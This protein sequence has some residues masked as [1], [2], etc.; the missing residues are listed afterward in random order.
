MCQGT[1]RKDPLCAMPADLFLIRHAT[2]DWT[3]T[4]LRYDIP[5]GPPLTDNGRAEAQL[6]GRFLAQHGVLRIFVSPM[7]RAHDTAAISSGVA[8]AQV[9]VSEDLT[10]WQRGEEEHRVLERMLRQFA[11]A[12]AL[13]EDRRPV[14]LVTHGGPIR[15]LLSHYGVD[16]ATI[17]YYRRQFDRDNPVP[18]AGVWRLSRTEIDGAWTASLVFSPV[19]YQEFVPV[20]VIV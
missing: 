11:E 20:P 15:L 1:P 19:P 7:E 10:E 13:D 2:P 6:L 18:P 5:P 4:D 9:L 12:A 14:A 17:D 8:Q 3:R 16:N